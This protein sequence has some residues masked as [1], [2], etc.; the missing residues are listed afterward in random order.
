MTAD[1]SKDSGNEG[2][3]SWLMG[4]HTGPAGVKI[5]VVVLQ[6]AESRST[7]RL[8]HSSHTTL[9]GLGVCTGRTPFSYTETC[10]S[11]SVVAPLVRA[12]NWNLA[13]M[14]IE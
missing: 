8:Q 6:Q 14:P 12:R 1:A 11:M 13:K 3:Y 7:T 9:G 5:T 2:T 4:V 10:S